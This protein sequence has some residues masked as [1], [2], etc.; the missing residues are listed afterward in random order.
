M[1]WRSNFLFILIV[2]FAGF[3]TAVYYLSPDGRAAIQSIFVTQAGGSTSSEG[4]RS[5]EA[6]AINQ[7]KAMETLAMLRD[8]VYGKVAAKCAGMNTQEFKDAFNRGMQ[9]LMENAKNSGTVNT[10]EG[11][12]DK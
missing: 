11:A 7:S 9:K 12:E 2:Y 5:V 10:A 4:E 1:G 6:T 3:A 8:N